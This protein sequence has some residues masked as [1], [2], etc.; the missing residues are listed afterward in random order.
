M[1]PRH[2]FM[3]ERLTGMCVYCGA[4]PDTRDHVPSKVLLDEPYPA[5]LPVVGA[6]DWCNASFS[7]DEQYLACFIDCVICGGTETAGLRRP[8]VK[9]ILDGNPALQQRIE[10]S[11]RKD[12]AGNLLWEPE[13]NRVRNVVLKLARGHTSY[14]LYPKF[15]KPV[16]VTFAPLQ[17]LREE[18]RSAFEQLT[19][20]KLDLCPEIGSRALLRTFGKSPDRFEQSGDWI[21]VQPGRYRYAVAETGGVLARMVLSEYLACEVVWEV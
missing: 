17:V 10:G 14:E 12:E 18:E 7:L 4:Q 13:A 5:Q 6:C 2:L 1:D 3:D 8:N 19:S 16:E 9:R 20:G 15:E 11:R 21:V